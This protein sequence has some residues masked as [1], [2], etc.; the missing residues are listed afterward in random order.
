MLAVVLVAVMMRPHDVMHGHEQR[1]S[2]R[3]VKPKVPWH[4]A[5]LLVTEYVIRPDVGC[6]TY[7]SLTASG[8]RPERGTVAVDTSQ[9]RFG[10]RFKIPGYGF[11]IARDTG[12]GVGW[13][14]IDAAVA[15]CS[16]A[17]NWGIK[18]LTVKYR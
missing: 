3:A 14:H 5:R 15:R 12:D 13:G 2:R 16:T 1:I 9:F 7:T 4:T 17:F 6:E 18:Y 11:G 10:T 8:S